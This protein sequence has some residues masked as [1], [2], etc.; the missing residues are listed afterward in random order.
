M[1]EIGVPEKR[2]VLIPQTI[3]AEPNPYTTPVPEPEKVEPEKVP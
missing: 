1:A 3:P 2:R